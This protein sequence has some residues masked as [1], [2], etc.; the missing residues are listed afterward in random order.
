MTNPASV[1]AGRAPRA[2]TLFALAGSCAAQMTPTAPSTP[3]GR[4][5][6]P[7]FIAQPQFG[8][9][10]LSLSWGDADGDGDFDVAKASGANTL[11]INNGGNTFSA[12]AQFGSGA[13]FTVVFA[14]YDNDG[15]QDA[16]VA[17]LGGPCL[18][19]V[20][21]GGGVF[22]PQPQFGT[23]F[24]TT[25]MAWADFDLDGDLDLATGNG[26]L[27][28]PQQ[29]YLYV[30]NGNGTFTELPRF[31]TGQTDSVAWGDA[32]GDGDP[33]LAVGNGGY[34][35][36][37]QNYLYLNNGGGSF[38]ERAEFGQGDTTCV[39]W[40]DCD[41]DGDLDLAVANWGGGSSRLYVNHGA[42]NF[43]GRDEF[44]ANDSNSV[45][46]ADAD[47][48]G[49]LDAATANGTFTSGQQNYLYL[50]DGAGAFTEVPE[51]GSDNTN[52]IAWCD[53]D[54]DG[55]LDAALGN[56]DPGCALYVNQ[57]ADNDHLI[58]HLVGHRHD[59]GPG[60]SNRDGIGAAIRVYEQGHLGQPAFLLGSRQIEAHG[61]FNAQGSIDAAFGLPADPLV[62]VRIV[63]P[64]SGGSRIVQ[65]LLGVARGQRLIVH[66]A[67]VCYPDCNTDGQLT[68]ADFGCF[69][70][71]FVAGDPYADCNGDGQRTVADFGCFQ[72]RFVTGC[73]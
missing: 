57:S 1:S 61:G 48:D 25:A 3:V 24:Q 69:Q 6:V 62:D 51:F 49:D 15:D 8:D 7:V 53:A 67:A 31:G 54:A 72:T 19:Y 23:G 2:V 5:S 41:N 47:N 55:D 73:P 21:A 59:R 58:L 56:A 40:A 26:I 38:T 52:V 12:V 4:E 60:Y 27:G 66:E 10:T 70:T 16:A 20:N 36:P 9:G 45:S 30:N 65:D 37:E 32:D 14:D 33:D 35:G 17:N 39:A 42:G 50:N 13:T 71:K 63:W 28:T 44:G 43:A 11:W 22:I 18:L 46:W 34:V 68:V 29:N 64:G